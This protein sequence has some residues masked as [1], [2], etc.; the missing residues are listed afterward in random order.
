M[1]RYNKPTLDI[2][3]FDNLDVMDG[4]GNDDPTGG[5][6]DTTEILQEIKPVTVDESSD[7]VG[8]AET[9]DTVDTPLDGSTD[10][11]QQD[12]TGSS[13]EGSGDDAAVEETVPDDTVETESASDDVVEE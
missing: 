13:D 4:S 8:D 11:S 1:K 9:T 10:A 6:M 12:D 2:V 5:D 7:H 3:E